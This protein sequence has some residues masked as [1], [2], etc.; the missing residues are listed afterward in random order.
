MNEYFKDLINQEIIESYQDIL[1]G[2]EKGKLRSI[3][4]NLRQNK[5]IRESINSGKLTILELI[6]TPTEELACDEIKKKREV[7]RKQNLKEAV[8]Q[9]VKLSKDEIDIIINRVEDP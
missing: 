1:K 2:I 7:Y 6:N 5:T 8:R 3:K 9:V 4:S